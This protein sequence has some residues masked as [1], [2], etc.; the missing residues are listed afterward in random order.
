MIV[1]RFTPDADLAGGD[2][3][4]TA[5]AAPALAAGLGFGFRLRL[6][7][8]APTAWNPRAPAELED[9]PYPAVVLGRPAAY[10][11]YG[12]VVQLGHV[13]RRPR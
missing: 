7:L 1:F 3:H 12:Y 2:H 10:D 6:T 5:L 4:Y 11:A 8:H 13:P 9:L